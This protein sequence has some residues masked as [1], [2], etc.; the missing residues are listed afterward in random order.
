MKLKTIILII[1]LILVSVGFVNAAETHYVNNYNSVD[2]GEIRWG[3]STKYSSQ[4]AYAVDTWN[5]LGEI[6][7][8]PD[9][10]A[11]YEDLTIYDRYYDDVDWTGKYDND[12]IGDDQIYFNTYY[13]DDA[14]ND[15]W[16]K[17]TALHELGH[18]LGLAHHRIDFN[19]M[20]EDWANIATLGTQDISDYNYLWSK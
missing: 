10:A 2:N 3:G 5:E 16:I 14:T 20:F 17:N 18:A 4:W 12:I 7:I 15:D 13:L 1:S 6:N 11:T 9:T 8:A 19:V